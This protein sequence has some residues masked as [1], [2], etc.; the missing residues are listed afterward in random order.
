MDPQNSLDVF[1]AQFK[2]A[3]REHQLGLLKRL[4]EELDIQIIVPSTGPE[5]Q[6]GYTSSYPEDVNDFACSHCG[7]HNI[8]PE[9]HPSGAIQ[10]TPLKG[11]P[12]LGDVVPCNTL[13]YND[14]EGCISYDCDN[15]YCME[16]KEYC[17]VTVKGFNVNDKSYVE[18]LELCHTCCQLKTVLTCYE[19]TFNIDQTTTKSAK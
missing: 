5:Q 4:S 2:S 13:H 11:R 14:M 9:F 18:M 7:R 6:V 3:D 17:M 16:C 1:A 19:G 15:R 8:L 10:Q 12:R